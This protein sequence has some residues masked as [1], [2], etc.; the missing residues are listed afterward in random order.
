[1]NEIESSN[2]ETTIF[3]PWL[4]IIDVFC[5]LISP[6]IL[7]LPISNEIKDE[8]VTRIVELISSL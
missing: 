4:S 7:C 3:V 2:V 5:V 6:R 1:M 8:E